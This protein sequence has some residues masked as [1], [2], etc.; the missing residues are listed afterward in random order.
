MT[1]IL[2]RGRDRHTDKRGLLLARPGQTKWFWRGQKPRR[3]EKG[4]SRVYF[5]NQGHVY[6][7][8]VYCGYRHQSGP[9]LQGEHQSGGSLGVRGPAR[10][11]RPPVAVA[12]GELRG[13]WR[14]RY[15]TPALARQLR[16]CKA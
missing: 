14:W 8:A 5:V 6:A 11:L 9:N 13:R 10:S 2:M 15:I 1:D 3:I 16:R 7:W 12:A 4:V